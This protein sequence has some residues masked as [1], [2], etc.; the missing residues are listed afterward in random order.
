MEEARKFMFVK[1]H[2]KNYSPLC[3]NDLMRT[4]KPDAPVRAQIFLHGAITDNVKF[5]R[6]TVSL[7]LMSSGFINFLIR[8]S[9]QEIKLLQ[10][11]CSCPTIILV[12]YYWS[13]YLWLYV[14]QHQQTVIHGEA[15]V[16]EKF[17]LTWFYPLE[18]IYWDCKIQFLEHLWIKVQ[19]D[20][21]WL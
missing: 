4:V 19:F 3:R 15:W 12:F 1:E 5:Q 11:H 9:S 21:I 10:H 16:Q 8:P 14:Y 17:R 6:D 18:I 20:V 13:V 2:F 7:V